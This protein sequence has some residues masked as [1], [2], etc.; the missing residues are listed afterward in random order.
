MPV[1][2]EFIG[3]KLIGRRST[4]FAEKSGEY[5]SLH[6]EKPKYIWLFFR[7]FVTL[8]SKMAKLLCLGKKRNQFLCFALDF[9]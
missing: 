7:F 1:N 9:S 5:I 8:P 6:T 4:L 2:S 3:T